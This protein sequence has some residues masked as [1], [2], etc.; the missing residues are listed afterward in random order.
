MVFHIFSI[1]LFSA[2]LAF[3]GPTSSHFL[4]A[5]SEL[6]ALR[7][8]SQPRRGL[9]ALR[10]Q[11]LNCLDGLDTALHF[12]LTPNSLRAGPAWQGEAPAAGLVAK[13]GFVCAWGLN[14]CATAFSSSVQNF[15]LHRSLLRSLEG[16]HSKR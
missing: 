2:H 15:Q 7:T 4:R 8:S 13:S 12:A 14:L 1:Q 5:A 11:L 9:L 6:L 3:A 10:H 16:T